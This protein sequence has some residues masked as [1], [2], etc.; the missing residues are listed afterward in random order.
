VRLAAWHKTD[1]LKETGARDF[2]LF[3]YV[4][5]RGGGRHTLRLPLRGGTHDWEPAEIVW[6]PAREI[7]G[8]TLYVGMTRTTGTAWIDDVYLGPAPEPDTPD[9]SAAATAPWRRSAVTVRFGQDGWIKV[10]DG[11]WQRGADVRITKEGL[12]RVYGAPEPGAEGRQIREV[13][14]DTTPP[15]IELLTRPQLDQ[16]G[17]VYQA[18]PGTAFVFRAVDTLSGVDRLEVAVDGGEFRP[19]E[20][21]LTLPPGP[22][23]LRCRA[24]DHA[25]N[26]ATV[27]TGTALTGGE[28]DCVQLTVREN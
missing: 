28:T 9:G 4:S 1:G 16:Q 22:H 5:Y 19:F 10:D 21:P 18:G 13:R 8:A 6:E 7:S 20:A 26:S 2:L 17:G 12:T 23:E 11:E 27:I 3:A 14:I 15:V 24:V 25:G